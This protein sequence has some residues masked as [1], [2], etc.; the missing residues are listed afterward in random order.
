MNLFQISSKNLT[1][2]FIHNLFLLMS[3]SKHPTQKS[4][5]ISQKLKEHET[6]F[7]V[8]LFSKM[9]INK[10]EKRTARVCLQ[11]G[12]KTHVLQMHPICRRLLQITAKE[13]VFI[14]A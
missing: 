6:G 3:F 14:G 5:R 11:S 8:E 12:Y 9:R 4:F 13:T 7:E 2:L 10:G 1:A